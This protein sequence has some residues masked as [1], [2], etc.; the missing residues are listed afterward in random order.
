MEIWKVGSGLKPFWSDYKTR[1]IHAGLRASEPTRA[2][3]L[4][5]DFDGDFEDDYD[6]D[7]D[8]GSFDNAA[9][10]SNALDGS[11]ED[12]YINQAQILTILERRRHG[13]HD[14]LSKSFQVALAH[15]TAD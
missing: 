12:S 5:E 6:G 3:R 1:R 15:A 9:V 10:I 8:Y 11:C 7:A 2:C 14:Q 13:G 4:V